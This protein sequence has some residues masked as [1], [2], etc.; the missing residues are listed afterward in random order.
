MHIPILSIC[1]QVVLIMMDVKKMQTS[2]VKIID[3]FLHAL[4]HC[5]HKIDGIVC[6]KFSI[7]LFFKKLELFSLLFTW[8]SMLS[9]LAVNV[10]CGV[11]V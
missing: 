4:I 7:Y 3:I 9:S 11:S 2:M 6:S 5:V 8:N 1:S 10:L